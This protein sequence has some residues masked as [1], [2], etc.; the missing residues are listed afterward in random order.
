ME[1]NDFFEWVPFYKE[2]AEKLLNY[3]DNRDDLINIIKDSY[4]QIGISLPT[5]DSNNNNDLIDID[6]FTVF[7]LFNKK[8][9]EE[10]RSLVANQ[11]GKTIGVMKEA[12]HSYNGIPVLNNQNATYFCFATDSRRKPNDIQNLWDLFEDA[13]EYANRSDNR[14]HLEES[15]DK[16]MKMTGIGNSKLT[17]ALYWIA[18]ETFL[19]LDSRDTWYIYESGKIPAEIVGKLPKIEPKIPAARYFDIVETI[20]AYLHGDNSKLKDYK[21][22]SFEAWRY[23]EEVNQQNKEEKQNVTKGAGLGDEDIDEKRYWLYSPGEQASRWNDCLEKGVMVIGWGDMGDLSQY[24]SRAEMTSKMKEIYDSNRS[25]IMDSLA[26]W[27]FSREM[28]IGDVVYVKKGMYKIIGRGIVTSDYYYDSNITDNFRNCRSVKWIDNGEWPHPGKAVMK[29]LT[30]ISAYKDYLTELNGLFIDNDNEEPDEII[31]DKK[32]T[33]YDKDKFLQEVYLDDSEYDNLVDLLMT[34]KNIVLQGA[35]GVGKTF[36]AKRLAYSIIGAK[37]PSRV[38]MVQFHQS[39]SYED[40][41]EGYRPTEETFGFERKKGVFTRFCKKAEDDKENEYFFIIDE[42]NR[43]NLSK[44]FGELFMLIE[45][46]KR[47]NSLPLLYSGDSFNVPENVYIIGMMNTADRSLAM[48][49]Y[50]LR[51]RFA[52]YDMKPAFENDKFKAYQSKHANAKFN[53]LIDAVK[54]LNE[55]IKADSSLG[56]GFCIGHSYFCELKEIKENTLKNIVEFELIPLVKEY[57]FDET[58][59][60]NSAITKLREAVK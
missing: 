23:S 35:P 15:F 45:N 31:V 47:G 21:E 33:A 58:T 59:K 18:P 37:D 24:E 16:C 40:F 55:D 52:F 57:W 29:V 41:I 38:E 10:N 60:R 26:T 56:E 20:T 28:K 5:L 30:D 1:N 49:D 14:V 51:R 22:L 50:A 34:K 9:T 12:P 6:P 48:L 8:M 25:Y 19:N 46:D 27:Q 54:S 3:K 7:G 42:I 4:D 32:T 44:I 43:G 17:M 13:L 53:K 11:L 36:I 2:F 39:Y